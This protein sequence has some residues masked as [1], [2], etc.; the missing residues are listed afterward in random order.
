[1]EYS[2]LYLKNTVVPFKLRKIPY[3]IIQI[4]GIFLYGYA[5]YCFLYFITGNKEISSNMTLSGFIIFPIIQIVVSKSNIVT[6]IVSA[7][8]FSLFIFNIPM[9]LGG[10]SSTKVT[11]Y[12]YNSNVSVEYL[13]FGNYDGMYQFIRDDKVVLIPIDSGYIEYKR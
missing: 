11:Y 13:Y 6:F 12:N 7:V 4:V 10:L 5:I 3:S 1:M 2:F 8:Y 9:Q